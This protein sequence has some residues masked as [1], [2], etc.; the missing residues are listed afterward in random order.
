[1]IKRRA[2]GGLVFVV[3]LSLAMILAAAPALAH[4]GGAVRAEWE[5]RGFHMVIETNEL[6]SAGT[7]GGTV[8]V[9]LIPT[10]SARDTSVRLR[11]LDIEVM[12]VGPGGATAGPIRAKQ[13]LSGAYEADLMVKQPGEWNI[14]IR[15]GDADTTQA[16]SFVFSLDVA[17]RNWWSDLGVVGG[18]LLIPVL[19]LFGMVRMA[20]KRSVEG[21]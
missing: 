8:H 7:F 4:G 9:T 16:Q 21:G 19:A 12:G 17:P 6:P 10:P 13:A 15:V 1:M 2:N 14:N 3:V 20:K 11:H 18:L 5:A